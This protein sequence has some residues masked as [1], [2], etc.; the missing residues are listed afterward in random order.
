MVK[1]IQYKLGM[2]LALPILVL[3]GA[4]VALVLVTIYWCAIP[5]AR[6][7]RG[8]RGPTLEFGPRRD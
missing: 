2:L 4:A 6:V 8:V 7:E 3:A 1:D 5:F